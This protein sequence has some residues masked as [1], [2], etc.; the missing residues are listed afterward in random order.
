MVKRVNFILCIF[1]HEIE[2][3]K[4]SSRK[5]FPGSSDGK[6]SVCNVGDQDLI[7]G[8]RRSPGGGLGNSLQYSC[9]GRIPMS[10]GALQATVHGV[11]KNQT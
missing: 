7:P 6:E 10:R 11:T 5:D 4:S 1:Y 3:K 9:L 8:L 2:K